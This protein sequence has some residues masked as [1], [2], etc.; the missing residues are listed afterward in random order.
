MDT[1]ASP[2]SQ[3]CLDHE[4]PNDSVERRALEVQRQPNGLAGARLAGAQL[5]EVLGRLRRHSLSHFWCFAAFA[6]NNFS[7]GKRQMKLK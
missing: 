1:H 4:A 5:P 2:S 7:V 6:C 3:P